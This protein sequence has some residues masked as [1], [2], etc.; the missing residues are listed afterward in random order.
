MNLT[1]LNRFFELK[2]RTIQELDKQPS[3]Q[4][5]KRWY[6]GLSN[7]DQSIVKA[8]A[9]LLV[10]ALVFMLVYAP[11]LQSK[12][13]AEAALARNVSTYNLIAKNA[14]KFGGASVS[15]TGQAAI[16]TAVMQ[17]SQKQGVALSRYEQDGQSLRIWLDRA[18]FD[19]AI[20]LLENLQ[21]SQGIR[22]SQISVDQTDRVGRVDIR[23]T[24][25]R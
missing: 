15:G 8:V 3:V 21:G 24:L 6:L 2:D 1:W 23:A 5:A 4:Q 19:D 13:T 18:A 10:A 9:W 16:L 22:A 14:G 25:T 12:K 11:L 7:R 20:T 17:Q